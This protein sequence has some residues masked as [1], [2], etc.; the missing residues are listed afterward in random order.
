RHRGRPAARARGRGAVAELRGVRPLDAQPGLRAA[1]HAWRA[2]RAR[3][4]LLPDR[5]PVPLQYEV[6]SALGAPLPHL[7]GR[8]RPAARRAGDA[9]GRGPVAQA[10]ALGSPQFGVVLAPFA[11]S[12]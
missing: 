2:D 11:T 3:K 5:E 7:R 10:T 6:L 8:S 9:V 4:S 1:G 12:N